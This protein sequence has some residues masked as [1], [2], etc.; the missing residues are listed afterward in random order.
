MLDWGI[1]N[2]ND[3]ISFAEMG[4]DRTLPRW[5]PMDHTLPIL[6]L[7]AGNKVVDGAVPLD[8]PEWNGETDAIPYQSNSVGGII[9]THFMEHIASPYN[10]LREA[11]RVLRAGCPFNILVPHGQSLMFAQDLDHKT[12][13]VVETWK[14]LLQN[15]YY[16]KDKNAFPFEIGA[17]FLFGLKEANLTLVTQ[18]IKA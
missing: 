16:G 4:L 1:Q 2:A 5:V 17:N 8:W 18:L 7:G 6:N 9:A 3:Y 11:G 12:P 14:T 10:I 13:Y 15:P